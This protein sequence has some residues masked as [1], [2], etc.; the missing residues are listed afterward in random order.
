MLKNNNSDN[1]S[2]ESNLAFDDVNRYQLKSSMTS[3]QHD[4]DDVAGI[5]FLCQLQPGILLRIVD[6]SVSVKKQA[7]TRRQVATPAHTLVL[8]FKLAGENIVSLADD[9]SDAIK[10]V[11]KAMQKAKGVDSFVVRERSLWVSYSKDALMAVDEMHN[12]KKYLLVQLMCDPKVLC[13]APFDLQPDQLPH[14]IASVVNG[15]EFM[16]ADFTL[17]DELMQALYIL[18]KSDTSDPYCRAFL[19][20]KTVELMCLALRNVS[21]QE[22]QQEQSHIS[23]KEREQMSKAG[24]LLIQNLQAPPTQEALVQTL[25]IGKSRLKR[26]FKALYGCS[27]T[28]YILNARVQQ[29]RQLLTQ[30]RLNVTQVAMEVGY[31]HVGN[32]TTMFKRQLGITPKAFQ[33]MHTGPDKR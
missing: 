12:Q 33:L 24:Q 18:L 11:L 30:G 32:F 17:T 7:V 25:G 10:A 28:D 16:M 2:H 27:I 21:Q 19:Q 26:C 6:C 20:A 14:C 9:N 5:E 3:I 8:N 31:E 4:S 22:R 29:A 15:Q 13:K 1:K 23:E